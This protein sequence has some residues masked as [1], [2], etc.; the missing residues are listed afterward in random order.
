[1][2]EGCLFFPSGL[3]SSLIDLFPFCDPRRSTRSPSSSPP[4]SPPSPP[5]PV[6]FCP[7]SRSGKRSS[8]ALYFFFLCRSVGSAAVRVDIV[9][10]LSPSF[11]FYREAVGDQWFPRVFLLPRF[12]VPLPGSFTLPS[13]LPPFLVEKRSKI[14]SLPL[15]SSIT[16]TDLFIPSPLD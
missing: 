13:L 6:S 8:V 9:P 2:L 11:V 12:H 16:R 3:L 15:L 1:M 5:P 4:T 7:P 14:P 10:F